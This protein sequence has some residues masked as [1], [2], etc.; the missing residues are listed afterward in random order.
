MI[1]SSQDDQTALNTWCCLEKGYSKLRCSTGVLL[2]MPGHGLGV[3]GG[4]SNIRPICPGQGW[5][6]LFSL[7]WA[8]QR[9]SKLTLDFLW[10]QFWSQTMENVKE[11]PWQ[12]CE[13]VGMGVPIPMYKQVCGTGPLAA[14]SLSPPPLAA[15]APSLS[16]YS[17][18]VKCFLV[19]KNLDTFRKVL[20]TTRTAH[21]ERMQDPWQLT[22]RKHFLRRFS[23]HMGQSRWDRAWIQMRQR[24]ALDFWAFSNEILSPTLNIYQKYWEPVHLTKSWTW[25]MHRAL[26]ETPTQA[27]NPWQGTF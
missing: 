3:S 19:L 8:A 16:V 5:K 17:R 6:S 25:Q 9:F 11:L 26:K 10:S 15:L 22:E 27:V 21:L 12:V 13:H 4:Q 1:F 2:A 23:V 14:A 24:P 20:S 7:A 18:K